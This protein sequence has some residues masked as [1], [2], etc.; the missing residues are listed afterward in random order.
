M[1]AYGYH[2]EQ[3]RG[4]REFVS[5]SSKV[6]GRRRDSERL[7]RCS[8]RCSEDVNGSTG[9]SAWT[10]LW[11]G[12]EG[13]AQGLWVMDIKLGYHA[14]PSSAGHRQQG[15]PICLSFFCRMDFRICHAHNSTTPRRLSGGPFPSFRSYQSSAPCCGRRHQAGLPIRGQAGSY[16]AQPGRWP[17]AAVH[18]FRTLTVNWALRYSAD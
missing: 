14:I 13:L 18:I 5:G 17:A 16:L 11:E 8:R 10:G 4:N 15:H 7:P 9:S 6:G 1:Q 3:G 2:D 12:V